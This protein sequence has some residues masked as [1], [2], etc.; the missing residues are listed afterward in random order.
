MILNQLL[1]AAIKDARLILRD[2]HAL[3][4]LFVM[5]VVFVAILSLALRDAFSERAGV[6]F[7]VLIVN[8]DR[9]VVGEKLTQAFLDDRHFRI[10]RAKAPLPDA[11]AVQSQVNA[12]RYQFALVIPD[13]ATSQ[14][15]RRALEQVRTDGARGK[16]P[17]VALRLLADPGLRADHRSLTLAFTNGALPLYVR[18]KLRS[19]GSR[20]S[21][22]G[23]T[24]CASLRP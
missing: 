24:N 23:R 11:D 15:R 12:G 7:S 14:A 1:T 9:G 5:P 2:R 13:N 21:V 4:I 3:A 6:T 16:T 19:S 22:I 10:E 20:C 17:P 8:H 18:F